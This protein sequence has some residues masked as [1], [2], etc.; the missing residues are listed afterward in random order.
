MNC[1]VHR[2]DLTLWLWRRPEAA[3]PNRALAWELPYAMGVSSQKRKHKMAKVKYKEIILK[4]A[5]E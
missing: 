5:K 4:S 1:V 3:A 2:S